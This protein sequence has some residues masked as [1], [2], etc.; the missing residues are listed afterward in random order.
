MSH[1]RRDDKSQT[2]KRGPAKAKWQARHPHD[3]RSPPGGHTPCP[4]TWAGRVGREPG[5]AYR[6]RMVRYPVSNQDSIGEEDVTLSRTIAAL[7]ILPLL[8]FSLSSCSAARPVH[9]GISPAAPPPHHVSSCCAPAKPVHHG[10]SPAALAVVRPVFVP[11]KRCNAA[12]SQAVVDGLAASNTAWNPNSSIDVAHITEYCG[13][14]Y[15]VVVRIK[16]KGTLAHNAY[17][18][19]AI[20]SL[21]QLFS[22]KETYAGYFEDPCYGDYVCWAHGS[23]TGPPDFYAHDFIEPYAT[24]FWYDLDH[25]A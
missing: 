14:A 23:G 4:M 8:V 7:A 12:I 20:H 6:G 13:Q 18:T 11:W 17:M 3:T 19:D 5:W 9:S 16:M 1:S 24:R 25:T 22:I 21:E 2:G 10:V 15:K